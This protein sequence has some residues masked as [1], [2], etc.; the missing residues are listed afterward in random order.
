MRRPMGGPRG[1]CPHCRANGADGDAS[2]DAVVSQLRSTTNVPHL[3]RH[4][5]TAANGL[6]FTGSCTDSPTGRMDLPLCTEEW[7]KK[8]HAPSPTRCAG[9]VK[10][11]YVFPKP[12]PGARES[13]T[14]RGCA[15]SRRR[16][17]AEEPV[18]RVYGL[19]KWL[20]KSYSA[21]ALS[22]FFV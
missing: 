8:T 14:P 12:P 16:R 7:R 1:S 10:Q 11:W 19:T 21:V 9:L 17:A 22:P 3:G 13:I 6:G 2:L 5:M 18:P 4:L 20:L 15:P